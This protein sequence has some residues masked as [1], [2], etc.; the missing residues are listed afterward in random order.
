[1]EYIPNVNTTDK[2]C[3]YLKTGT[4]FI[5]PDGGGSNAEIIKC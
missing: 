2:A 5:N 4:Y 1:M 3:G